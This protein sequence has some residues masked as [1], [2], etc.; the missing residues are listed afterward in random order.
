VQGRRRRTPGVSRQ[1]S[2]ASSIEGVPVREQLQAPIDL[3]SLSGCG[4]GLQLWRRSCAPACFMQSGIAVLWSICIG[5][6][7]DPI[8]VM[9]IEVP[10]SNPPELLV[11]HYRLDP[12]RLWQ[13]RHVND[14]VEAQPM[15][16]W[17]EEAAL[18]H[19]AGPM[20]PTAGLKA[21]ITSD[22]TRFACTLLR[23]H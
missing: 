1:G 3:A 6:D 4:P 9:V 13:P 21:A 16:P 5:C 10:G 19:G 2:N 23:K 12:L 17:A 15:A 14:E 18:P 22:P 20:S 11:L 8:S 7:A